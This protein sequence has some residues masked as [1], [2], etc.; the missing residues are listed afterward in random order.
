MFKSFFSSTLLLALVV[1]I[2]STQLTG[3]AGVVVGGAAT[4][5][6][7]VHDRR[8]TGVILDDQEIE[9][10]AM[11]IRSNDQ[12]IT[13]SSNIS[14]TSYNLV[15]LMTGQ[16]QSAAVAQRYADEIARLPRVRKVINE[17]VIGAERSLTE[18]T[19]DVYLTSRAKLALF[20]IELED[21][22]PTRI[23]VVT[24]QGTVYL[25]G[26][27]TRAEAAA[28]TEKVRFISGV[29]HVV[30]VFEYID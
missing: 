28:T 10:R 27:V 6:A 11:Q 2:F 21:F 18:S 14:V 5:V 30:K 17:V 19:S 26:L 15:A 9:L 20:D 4:G 25:M 1:G 23:K 29:K 7:V 13:D 3:C 22:D 16:A 24:S 8:T 12:Q